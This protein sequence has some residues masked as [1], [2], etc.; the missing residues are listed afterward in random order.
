MS[1]N[2]E[3]FKYKPL[4]ELW[5]Y[6]I[7]EEDRKFIFLNSINNTAVNSIESKKFTKPLILFT[8]DFYSYYEI[9][10]TITHIKKEKAL[11]SDDRY[12]STQEKN[13][14]IIV[15][16]AINKYCIK[17]FDDNR[18]SAFEVRMNDII[19]FRYENPKYDVEKNESYFGYIDIER[20][21]KKCSEYL[22]DIIVN[23]QSSSNSTSTITFV[24][25][26]IILF[27]LVFM[28]SVLISK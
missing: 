7:P 15:I 16:K 12:L 11:F 25:D 24:K 28:T 3:S 19:L 8:K 22:K 18:Y 17:E 6:I 27:G 5:N 4:D 9:D 10:Q 2:P 26:I 1:I 14:I 13:N 21:Q 23:D 20:L